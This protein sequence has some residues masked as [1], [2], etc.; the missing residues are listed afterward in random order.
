MERHEHYP[1]GDGRV[2]SRSDLE[3]TSR[4]TRLGQLPKATVEQQVNIMHAPQPERPSMFPNPPHFPF[5]ST[6]GALRPAYC[7]PGVNAGYL[8]GDPDHDNTLRY[9]AQRIP[10]EAKDPRHRNPD[11]QRQQPPDLLDEHFTFDAYARRNP[12]ADIPD[13]ESTSVWIENLPPNCTYAKLLGAI[14]DCGKVYACMINEPIQNHKGSAAKIVF[15]DVTG[16]TRMQRFFEQGRFIISSCMPSVR[17]HRIKTEAQEPGPQS[18][19]LVISGPP[20]V[21]NQPRLINMFKQVCTFDMESIETAPYRPGIDQGIVTIQFRFASYRYQAERAIRCLWQTRD[22]MLANGS[23]EEQ[24]TWTQVAARFGWDPCDR[25][26]TMTPVRPQLPMFGGHPF[27]SDDG[28][29]PRARLPPIGVPPSTSND[30]IVGKVPR[31]Q[32]PYSDLLFSSDDDKAHRSQLPPLGDPPS[33]MNND[34]VGKAP[35]RHPLTFGDHPSTSDNDRAGK[36]HHPQLPMYGDY[37]YNSDNRYAPSRF[38]RRGDNPYTSDDN[39]PGKAPRAPHRTYGDH[40]FARRAANA[41]R[42]QFSA[43]GGPRFIMNNGKADTDGDE[44]RDGRGTDK[45]A[46]DDYTVS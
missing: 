23:T 27:G 10:Y 22:K 36:A 46:L 37:Q 44:K 25:E 17:L 39:S 33:N 42:L 13:E 12:S 3:E 38:A 40:P 21:V 31:R 6:T 8:T 34:T 35:R 32:L 28:N 18:R 4:V 15:F 43:D 14:K 9:W 45:E 26:Y 30:D 16:R 1:F 5:P 41:P 24:H 7:L 2:S 20:K 29:A 11:R 19:V